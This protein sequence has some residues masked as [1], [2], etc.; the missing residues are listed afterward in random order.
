MRVHVEISGYYDWE[1]APE[2]MVVTQEDVNAL[3]VKQMAD[4]E[5][6]IRV[7]KDVDH[8]R[9]EHRYHDVGIHEEMLCQ[10]LAALEFLGRE[11]SRREVIA[12]ILR[13]NFRH[14]LHRSHLVKINL[15]EDG[16]QPELYK[17]CLLAAGVKQVDEAL[18]RYMDTSEGMEDFLNIFFKTDSV[19][20]AAKNG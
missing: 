2:N 4:G 18:D 14:H 3:K 8:L 9:P 11:P 20:K 7:T 13:D 10:R 12:E 1:P 19:R 16:P 5:W 6:H 15:H 17:A